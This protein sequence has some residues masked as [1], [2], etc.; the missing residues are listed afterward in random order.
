MC[1]A[2]AATASKELVELR[3]HKIEGVE[4]FPIVV[5]DDIESISKTNEITKILDSLKLTQ[6]ITRLE[7]RKVTFRTIKT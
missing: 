6:D 1:S 5:S 3:G 7:S 2:I 4:S